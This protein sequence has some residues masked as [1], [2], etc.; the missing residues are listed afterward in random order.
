MKNLGISAKLFLMGSAI[1]ML[2]PIL[3]MT[4]FFKQ[5][6]VT[7][8]NS[9]I[10][11]IKLQ[12][13]KML[14]ELVFKF[15][16]IRLQVRTVPVIGMSQI[17]IDKYLDLTKAAVA[18]FVKG[19]KNFESTIEGDVERKKFDEFAKS[20]DEF[21]KFG[22]ELIELA[23][24]H[25]QKKIEEVARLVREVCPVKA[26]I[27][28]S[29]IAGL[30]EQQTIEAKNLVELAHIEENETKWIL[31]GSS[32]F[33]FFIAI[34]LSLLNAKSLTRQLSQMAR[35]LLFSSDKIRAASSQVAQDS[36]TL[37]STTSQQA[38]ALE[39]T[40][41]AVD[42]INSMIGKNSENAE[43]S[44]S[45]ANTSLTTA[46]AG[47]ALVDELINEVSEIKIS[48][49][50]LIQTV[51]HGNAEISKILEVITEIET[52]TKVINEIVFQTKLLSFNASVEAARAG[53]AGKGFA[54]V[55][56]EVGNLANVSGRSSNE[57]SDLLAKSV[58]IVKV[59][60]DS[61]KANIEVK[62]KNSSARVERGIEIGKR[63][64]ETLSEVLE[65]S[66]KISQMVSE[67]TTASKEQ[68]VGVSEVSQ[69]MQEIDSVTRDVAKVSTSSAETAQELSVQSNQMRLLVEKLNKTIRGVGRDQILDSA[70]DSLSDK[71]HFSKMAS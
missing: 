2:L 61:T 21:L 32:L 39:Q 4:I 16:N 42:E 12:K 60:V 58:Q 59:I 10:S 62:S 14:G 28:E 5:Q 56:E 68:S 36:A 3:G 11:D 43:L 66:R 38:S 41:T 46:E 29:A 40:V 53:E 47:K 34:S 63:C 27:V 35:D 31:I 22:V 71:N 44:K 57:I 64:G 6:K 17:E 30:I 7:A 65:S 67:I 15:R 55:A 48:N 70:D 8:I 25:D 24:T 49:Q 33:G 19:K 20:A 45:F 18:E 50:D 51:N 9:Q 26:A 23:S 1:G 54:I 13:T 52:K 69:S 37:S